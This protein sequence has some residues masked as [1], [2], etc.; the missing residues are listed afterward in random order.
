MLLND[1][2][3][4][5]NELIVA[6][7]ES[8]ARYTDAADR[9]DDETTTFLEELGT[10]RE[11]TVERLSTMIRESGELPKGTDTERGQ[12]HQ[13]FTRARAALAEDERKVFVDDALAGERRIAS[14][15]DEVMEL[16]LSPETRGYI[17]TLRTREREVI[18]RLVTLS[19][20]T[21][22]DGR[23]A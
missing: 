3:M 23:G 1:D 10:A 15:I 21:P 16:D 18:A 6:Y 22:G 2:Q 19:D 5:I 11:E 8:I 14:L 12:L 20:E 13:L 9:V 17:E 7:R 4:A